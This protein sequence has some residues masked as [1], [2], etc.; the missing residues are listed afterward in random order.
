MDSDIEIRSERFTER[1]GGDSIDIFHKMNEYQTDCLL[2]KSYCDIIIEN[3]KNKNIITDYFYK[4][5]IKS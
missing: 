5:I 3:N 2:I 4:D 1:N